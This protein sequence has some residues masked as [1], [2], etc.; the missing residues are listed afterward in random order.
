[1]SSSNSQEIMSSRTRDLHNKSSSYTKNQEFWKSFEEKLKHNPKYWETLIADFDYKIE[2]R[3]YLKDQALVDR[4][5][6][7]EERNRY[8]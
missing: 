2:N 1:M 3:P 6:A 7:L 4:K 8:I 5:N